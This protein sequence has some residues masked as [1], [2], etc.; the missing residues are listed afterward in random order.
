MELS[1][2]KYWSGSPFPSPGNLP[3]PGIKLAS[4]T[5]AGR[6]FTTEPPGKPI[7]LESVIT[8]S[9]YF[10]CLFHR[11]TIFVNA[12]GSCTLALHS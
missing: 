2:Q 9:L 11:E 5:L 1:R 4:P 3:A 10:L 12:F 6:F 8:I 7:R